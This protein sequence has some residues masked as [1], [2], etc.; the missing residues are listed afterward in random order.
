[1]ALQVK[2]D[3][4]VVIRGPLNLTRS[5]ADAFAAAHLDW[6]EKQQKRMA[7]R[8]VPGEPTARQEEE[9]RRVLAGWIAF[10]EPKLGV[11]SRGFRLTGAK[12]RLGS[13]TPARGTLCFSRYLAFYPPEA[14]EYV[15][16]HELCHLRHPDHSPAFHRLVASVLP[17]EKE[18]IRIIHA[19]PSAR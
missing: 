9:L 2:E 10:Y 14:V 19:G 11:K 5:R 7:A 16:V 3:G 17:D 12:K 18:R 15:A 4:S 6:I 1:M 8:P 13:C